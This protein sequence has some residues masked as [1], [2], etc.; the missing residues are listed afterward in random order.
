MIKV[1]SDFIKRVK[2]EL[3]R[4]KKEYFCATVYVRYNIQNT[5]NTLTVTIYENGNS[6]VFETEIECDYMNPMQILMTDLHTTDVVLLDFVL[7]EQYSM[8]CY[9]KNRKD[10]R[11][12][13]GA[14]C[15]YWEDAIIFY[16]QKRTKMAKY[17]QISWDG[18]KCLQRG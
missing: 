17:I 5:H 6:H 1:N 7:S 18:C 8:E 13:D 14:G 12:V 15:D 16:N 2:K 9:I 10:F 3:K 4:A 11:F